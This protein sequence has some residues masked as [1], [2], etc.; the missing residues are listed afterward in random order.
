M[1]LESSSYNNYLITIFNGITSTA[2]KAVQLSAILFLK[3]TIP[4]LFNS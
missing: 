4:L 1:V 2:L 3:I